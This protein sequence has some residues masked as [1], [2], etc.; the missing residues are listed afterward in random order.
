MAKE[1]LKK[2]FFGGFRKEDVIDYIEKIE[3]EKEELA[4]RLRALEGKAEECS[5][6]ESRLDDANGANER[7]EAEN[8]SLKKQL[9][10]S[11]AEVEKYGEALS[12]MEQRL[13]ELQKKCEGITNSEK[14]ISGLV[15]D[16]VMYSDR[17]IGKAKDA[18]KAVSGDACK[19][20]TETAGE[21]DRIGVEIGRISG[22]FSEVV[23]R[24]SAKL[25]ALSTDISELTSRFEQPEGD[26]DEFEQFRLGEDGLVL[27]DEIFM[28]S[29]AASS[30]A[31]ETEND[32][33]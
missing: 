17:I 8:A 20:I 10:E 11:S 28:K 2:S 24:L 5:S 12:A 13:E 7:L 14:Q 4:V 9:A 23:T 31:D 15:M 26:S 30:T 21:I 19:T 18:A 32:N 27:L 25:S 22:D 1:T 6:L 16:A 33:G 29:K 3:T